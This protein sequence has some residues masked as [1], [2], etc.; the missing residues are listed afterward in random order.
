[1]NKKID[2]FL[3]LKIFV[4]YNI[5]LSCCLFSELPPLVITEVAPGEPGTK[6]WVEIFVSS[7]GDYAGWKIESECGCK[8]ETLIF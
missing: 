8:Y 5:V 3:Y 1:M 2:I 4:F 7:S 6:D